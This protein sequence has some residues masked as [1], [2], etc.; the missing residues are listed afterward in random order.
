MITS[1]QDAVICE[2][3]I[4]APPER[5]FKA[6]ITREQAIEW[7]S[8]EQYETTEWEMDARLGGSWRFTARKRKEPGAGK[9]YKHRGEILEIDPPRVLTYTWFTDFH[10][11][12]D[13]RTVVRWELTS[14]SAGTHVKVTHSG[15]AA[16]PNSRK[17]YNE[18]WPGLL[19][20]IK[21]FIEK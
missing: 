7:G 15:L 8:D 9:E 12:R 16:L 4:A 20:L 2:I 10:E 6:L 1:D 14:T 19:Q 18:G 17:G 21:K 13:Q 5:V 3:D 11:V